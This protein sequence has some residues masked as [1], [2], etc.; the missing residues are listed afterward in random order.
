M[1]SITMKFSWRMVNSHTKT[2]IKDLG[3]KVTTLDFADENM[4]LN[5]R[6][7][8]AS[9]SI[10]VLVT[11][12]RRSLAESVPALLREDPALEEKIS[13][14]GWKPEV[15]KLAVTGAVTS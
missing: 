14:I 4:V 5:E 6:N 11:A 3:E 15:Y 9:E 13:G 12:L 7:Q 1:K 10:Q 8:V 2:I